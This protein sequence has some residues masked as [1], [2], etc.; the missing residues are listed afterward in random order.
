[1]MLM[2]QASVTTAPSDSSTAAD[3]CAATHKPHVT[4][5]LAAS[6]MK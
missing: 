2:K 4:G 5:A 3:G 6:S 1:M